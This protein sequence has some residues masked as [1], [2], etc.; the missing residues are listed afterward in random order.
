[1][2]HFLTV[3]EVDPD[4]DSR[5]RWVLHWYRYDPERKE[6]RYV[7][8]AAF[9]DKKEFTRRLDELSTELDRLQKE[10]QAEEIE[11]IGGVELP[12]GYRAATNDAR[13]KRQAAEAHWRHNERWS[14]R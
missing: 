2:G 14:N 4:D 9:D 12:A 1:M 5:K 10:G 13:R 8:V 11:R 6:R 7:V 3:A